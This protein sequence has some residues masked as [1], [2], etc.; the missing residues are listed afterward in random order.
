M[1][2]KETPQDSSNDIDELFKGTTADS[3]QEEEEAPK[4]EKLEAEGLVSES[5][6]AVL[7]KQP[8]E[9]GDV[10]H[11]DLLIQHIEVQPGMKVLE[12]YDLVKIYRRRR[13]V[14]HVDLKVTEGRI[15]G[16]LG[17]NGAGKT[18][19]FYMMVGLIRPNSGRIFMNGREITKIPIYQRARLGLGYLAQEPSIFRKLTVEENVLLILE[20]LGV[21]YRQRMERTDEILEEL[22]LT[23]L[24][25]SP[26]NTLSGGERRRCEIARALAGSPDF[27]LLDEPFTGVDPIAI[28]DIQRIVKM[29]RKKGIGILVTDHSVRDILGVSD[30]VYIMHQGKILQSGR[31]R[32]IAQS[33]I[34]KKYYLGERF[35]AD[36]SLLGIMDELERENVG[37][38]AET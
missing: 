27:M 35:Q 36:E 34:A 32:E 16:L 20:A 15:V 14:D 4:P 29:L 17:P 28:Q 3:A 24:R 38:G 21:P 23:R 33:E 12:A 30:W 26:G 31:S 8:A 25:R 6:T 22:D 2:D 5:R 10:V 19:S 1:T 9:P 11:G 13:V 7:S 18:T 37:E